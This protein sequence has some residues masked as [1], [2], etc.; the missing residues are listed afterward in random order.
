MS[1]Q[2][3]QSL[4]DKYG[5]PL[6]QK[7]IEKLDNY[8][9]SNGKKYKDDYKAILNWVAEE[10]EKKYPNLIRRSAPSFEGN[11][12]A[13]YLEDDEKPANPST[14]SSFDRD[15]FFEAAVA[16]SM[17]RHRKACS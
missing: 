16:A 15:E 7:M 6:T 5:E 11:P 2:E 17:D 4:V 12:F 3:Y 14:G 9:A 10:V 1:A 13:E 8:K